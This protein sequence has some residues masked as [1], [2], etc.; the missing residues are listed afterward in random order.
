MKQIFT[1]LV[2]IACV[3]VW[4]QET[5]VLSGKVNNTNVEPISGATIRV[6]NTNYGAVTNESG[7]FTIADLVK[8]RYT[9][10]ISAVGFASIK[11]DVDLTTI[12]AEP[13]R[14]QLVESVRQLD[15]VI[16]TA[17]KKEDDIQKIP[18]SISNISSVQVEQYRLWNAK[19][20]QEVVRKRRSCH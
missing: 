1:I 6:L 4:A 5:G 14:I 19:V 17:E 18:S 20:R 2:M 16:V 8:A 10:E 9:L 11:K 15:A 3:P 12:S 13:L 7:E